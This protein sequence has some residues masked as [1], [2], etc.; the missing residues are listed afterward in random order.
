MTDPR[1]RL[2]DEESS[3]LLQAASALCPS[4]FSMVPDP[5]ESIRDY[6]RRLYSPGNDLASLVA[7]ESRSR[8]A[9]AVASH[10]R[11]VFGIS[12]TAAA[13]EI[14]VSPVIQTG[15]HH[16]L[17]FDDDF[18]ST[19]ALSLIGSAS[20]R[21]TVNLLFTC[22]TITLE[23]QARHG[24]A[25]LRINAEPIRVFDIPRKTLSK[26]SVLAFSD[27]VTLS[28]ELR[29]WIGAQSATGVRIDLSRT[30]ARSA[31]EHISRINDQFFGQLHQ[32]TGVMTVALRE[33]FFARL[34]ADT[35]DQPSLLRRFTDDGRLTA[36]AARLHSAAS[37][38]AGCFVPV[39]TDLFWGVSGGRVRPLRLSAGRLQSARYDIDIP[40]DAAS[41]ARHLRDGAL[42]PGLFLV[43]CVASILP[44]ARALG[45]SYQAAYYEAFRN[46]VL[47][48]LDPAASDERQLM[49][50]IA[51]QALAGW[52]H[53]VIARNALADLAVPKQG[54]LSF[55][56]C[57]ADTSLRAA[58][59]EFAAFT[60][61]ERWR[62][63]A[64]ALG[65]AVP[66]RVS[67]GRSSLRY[68]ETDA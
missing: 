7:K 37:G 25:W 66:E 2:A 39:A 16:R 23:E 33:D 64:G 17:A 38:A 49:S 44:A 12:G 9:N 19:L 57:F 48:V 52:G 8:L 34:L 47:D 46:A 10:V 27:P 11:R 22:S 20:A 56:D 32:G 14:L 53:N 45:G 6:A 35:L 54:A 40:A 21:R 62:Q 63:L 24:P 55:P 26:K 5:D 29:S 36:L 31:S 3:L 18:C 61:D 67:A 58:S 13:A 65:G 42:V 1:I 41:L 30:E 28:E 68:T 50:D 60:A 43:F 15:P 4:S 59:D 51:G